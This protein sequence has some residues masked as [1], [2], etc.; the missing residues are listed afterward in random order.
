MNKLSDLKMA[1]SD[2]FF[3]GHSHAGAVERV[4]AK[5]KSHCIF[6]QSATKNP[7]FIL[8]HFQQNVQDL[9]AY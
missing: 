5:G 2:N 7:R 4:Q 8:P 6:N 3:A 1:Q 9:S